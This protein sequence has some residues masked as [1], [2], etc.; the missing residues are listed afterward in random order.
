MGDSVWIHD[1]DKPEKMFS[2][3]MK[4]FSLIQKSVDNEISTL[5]SQLEIKPIQQFNL[6]FLNSLSIRLITDNSWY[7]DRKYIR[8]DYGDELNKWIQ[9]NN[10]I[11]ALSRKYDS[12]WKYSEFSFTDDYLDKMYKIIDIIAERDKT[13]HEENIEKRESNKLTSSALS[14]L[15]ERIG[16]SKK[17]YGYS[18]KKKKDKEWLTYEWVGQVFNQI[19]TIYPDTKLDELIKLCKEKIKKYYDDEVKRIK[20]E[21]AKKQ[22]ELK[23]KEENKKL[24]LLLA[25]YDLDLTQDWEDLLDIVINKN[26]YLYLAYYLEKNRGDWNDGYSYA[27]TGLDNFTIENELDQDIHNDIYSYIEDWGGDGRVFRD[28]NYNYSYLYGIVADLE[29][30]LFKDFQVIKE[31][32]KDY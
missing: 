11:G 9:T 32:V 22:A 26:K 23:L 7:N 28:C 16:I 15:L 27:E 17:Y 14:S 2:E 13:I 3:L 4:G 18:S 29:P 21:E 5:K 20:E 24:A 6:L 8:F 25:K 30:D 12:V 1:T 10:E 31:N 19:P